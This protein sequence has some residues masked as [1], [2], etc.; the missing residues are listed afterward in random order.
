MQTVTKWHNTCVNCL[1]KEAEEIGST[2]LIFKWIEMVWY[3]DTLMADMSLLII[4]YCFIAYCTI[5]ITLRI[6]STMA[7][8]FSFVDTIILVDNV[9]MCQACNL[10][11]SLNTTTTRVAGLVYTY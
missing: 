8:T 5:S 2:V 7:L 4:K 11:N 10:G 9:R 3:C 6:T 1:P